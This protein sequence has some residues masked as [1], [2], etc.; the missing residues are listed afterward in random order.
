MTEQVRSRTHH[1]AACAV[2][3]AMLCVL[4]PYAI[5]I[6]LVPVTLATLVIYLTV[7]LL[8]WKW[9]T[10]SVCAYLL[11]GLAGV[12]VFSGFVGGAGRLLGPT[13]GYMVGYIPL[14]LIA[15]WVSLA[16]QGLMERGKTVPAIAIRY[17]GMVLGTAV[18]YAF[19]TAWYCFQGGRTL[20]AAVAACVT[21][22]IP[23]DLVKMALALA[24]GVPVRRR[25]EQAHLI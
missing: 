25:L 13:G 10:A 2:M 18:L 12:P 15:G 14:A 9:G 1:L 4:A 22:F 8:G 11:I 3:T 20:G 5:P 7:E 24:V 19:G 23:F 17:A 21:P 6:G 16:T